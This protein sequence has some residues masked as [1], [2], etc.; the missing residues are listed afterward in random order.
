MVV[1]LHI[2]I[3]I[4]LQ[5]NYLLNI[6]ICNIWKSCFLK[7]N[8]NSIYILSTTMVSNCSNSQRVKS[9]RTKD[10]E[11]TVKQ[12][13]AQTSLS[14]LGTLERTIIWSSATFHIHS[15]LFQQTLNISTGKRSPK[16]RKALLP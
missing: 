4:I 16:M 15:S 7:R 10:D 3:I 13:C 14:T 1:Y 2:Q 9:K 8:K 12:I 11:R 6:P 5:M